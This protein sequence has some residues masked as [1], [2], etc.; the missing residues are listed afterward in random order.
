[1]T[2]SLTQVPEKIILV[3]TVLEAYN[4]QAQQEADNIQH[5]VDRICL[6]EAFLDSAIPVYD[7]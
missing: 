6:Y 3:T 4:K 5:K 2:C 7:E 1:M